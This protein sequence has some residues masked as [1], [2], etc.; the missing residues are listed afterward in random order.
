[1]IKELIEKAVTIGSIRFI[2]GIVETESSD[3][4][5]NIAYQ[6]RTTLITVFL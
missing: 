6:I 4:L 3:V 5:K 2:S 1:M